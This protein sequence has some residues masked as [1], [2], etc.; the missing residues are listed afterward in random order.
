[1]G[2]PSGADA[3]AG[4][5]ATVEYDRKSSGSRDP[6]THASRLAPL[7]TTKDA[8]QILNVSPR[9]IRRLIASGSIGAVR[10]GRSVRIKRRDLEALMGSV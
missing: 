3:S 7:L 4:D 6:S 5:A 10:I 8:A 9:T 1:M 2:R